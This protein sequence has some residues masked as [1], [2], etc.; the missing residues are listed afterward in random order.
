MR[1]TKNMAVSEFNNKRFDK[2]PRTGK[3]CSNL[4]NRNN[5]N[6]NKFT[7]KNQNDFNGYKNPFLQKNDFNLEEERKNLIQMASMKNLQQNS[8]NKNKNKYKYNYNK[9]SPTSGVSNIVD[10]FFLRQLDNNN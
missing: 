5:I 7:F 2:R 10:Q 8:E 6:N 4:N 9:E 1:K 3:S